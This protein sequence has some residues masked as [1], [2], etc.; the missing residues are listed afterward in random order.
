M[1]TIAETGK[2]PKGTLEDSSRYLAEDIEQQEQI[3]IG[4]GDLLSIEHVDPVVNAKMRLVN[5][6]I[7]EIGMTW[8]QWKLFVLN[9]FGCVIHRGIVEIGDGTTEEV[10][11]VP[12]SEL[13]IFIT[14]RRLR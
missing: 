3:S 4:K 7:D 12:V 6:A 13:T 10:A 14:V 11:S 5:D 2:V 1:S 8:Y 9:G